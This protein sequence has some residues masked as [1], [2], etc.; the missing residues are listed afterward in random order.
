[1]AQT[2]PGWY[3]DPS[4][5]GRQRYFDGNQWTEHVHD[6]QQPASGQSPQQSQAEAGDQRDRTPS[7]GQPVT[8]DPAGRQ[9]HQ[10]PS[11]AQPVNHIPAEGYAAQQAQPQGQVYG[12]GGQPQHQQPQG[13]VYGQGGQPQHQQPQGQ[14]YGQGGQP[15]PQGQ[16]YGQG[17][18]PQHQQ[19]GGQVYGHQ[20]AGAPPQQPEQSQLEKIAELDVS[21]HHDP[22]AVQRQVQ[23]AGGGPTVQGGGT[24]FSEPV[25][26]VNQKTKLVEINNEYSVF[27]QH[28]QQ[29]A[30]VVQVGQSA[31]KKAVR[32]LGSYDQFFTHKLEVRDGH[33]QVLLRVTRPRK[34]FKSRIIVERGDGSAV[35]EIQQLN[36]VGKINFSMQ[37]DGQEYGQ[38]RGEN[39]RAWNFAIVDHTGAEVARITKTFEGIA[40]TLFTTADNYVLQIHRPLQEPLRS[41]VVASAL[42]VDT[43]LKQD[44]RGLG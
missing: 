10:V 21:G 7:Q 23:M 6:S 13:Q 31:L 17:G 38:I 44:D 12:Q 22:G 27:N 30:A 3:P 36:M 8:T 16:V 26:V 24:L 32:F 2:P 39:W 11:Q 20:H 41:L 37:V 28:G 18:Q 4:Q 40:K 43:A 34:V 35:G 14:V 5:P 42:T 15:Q 1:M 29:V 19:H 9:A 25:L 33:G